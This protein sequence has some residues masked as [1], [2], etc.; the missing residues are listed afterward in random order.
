MAGE[1]NRILQVAVDDGVAFNDSY[2]SRT[3]ALDAGSPGRGGQTQLISA[4]AESDLDF[5]DKALVGGWLLLINL[6]ETNYILAGPKRAD[7]SMETAQQIFPKKEA[8]FF[9]PPNVEYRA[10]ADTADCLLDV[11]LY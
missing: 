10:I 5:G 1:I 3:A 9:L 11:R 2:T 6:D 4:S 8:W 7:G